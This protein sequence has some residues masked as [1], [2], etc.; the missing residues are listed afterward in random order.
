M[1]FSSDAA[2]RPPADVPWFATALSFNGSTRRSRPGPAVLPGL[3]LMALLT[4]T[5]ANGAALYRD[6]S[7]AKATGL[8][9]A[10]VADA[11]RPLSAVASNPAG[12]ALASET[13]LDLEMH[14]RWI[15]AEFNSPFNSEVTLHDA[16]VAPAVA[17][18]VPLSNPHW[19]LGLGVTTP[20]AVRADWNY[21]DAPGGLEGRTS[22]GFRRHR[23][24]ILLLRSP[25]AVSWSPNDRWSVGAS[26]AH[27]FNRNELEAP[28]I[29]QSQPV[30]KGF[31]TLL[32]LDAEGHGWDAQIGGQIRLTDSLRIALTYRLP[33][34]IAATGTANGDAT[35]QLQS[36]GGGFATV[37][38]DFRYDA[39]VTT[40]FPQIASFGLSWQANPRWRV[41]AQL[42]WIDWSEAFDEL[43]IELTHGDNLDLNGLLGGSSATDVAPLRWRDQWVP[44]VG[45]EFQASEAWSIRAG[46]AFAKSAVPDDTL[47]PLTGAIFEHLVA[48]GFSWR[49]RAVRVD[50][51]WQWNLPASQSTGTSALRSSEYSQSRLEVEAHGISANLGFRF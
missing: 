22:Y 31:K 17:V 34:E 9:G 33:A 42:D 2:G 27:L 35:A 12:L 28:Y 40:R 29:F 25:L 38:P 46:Y 1:P 24:E 11:N 44:R 36:L 45:I 37:R 39:E 20:V 47:T 8:A 41:A 7:G 15:R 50:L 21:Q 43:R 16:G 26:V 13:E 32:D 48:A 3:A 5:H 51:A 6:G 19:A 4:S 49:H 18:A 23:S 30:L 14:A 10:D